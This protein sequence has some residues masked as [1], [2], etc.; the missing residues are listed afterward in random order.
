MENI[1]GNVCGSYFCVHFVN[2]ED[3]TMA[4]MAFLQQLIMVLHS[5]VEICH[6]ITY[7]YGKR[8]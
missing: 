2:F 5:H 4:Q 8:I 7:F 3:T 1:L 6:L